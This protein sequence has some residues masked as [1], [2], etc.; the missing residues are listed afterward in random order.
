MRHLPLLASSLLAAPLLA[1]AHNETADAGNTIATAQI[2]A[3]S[4]PLASITGT[5]N[6]DAD[7]FV[8]QIDNPGTFSATVTGGT[9]GDSMLFL[10]DENG[11]G[12]VANDDN[13]GG[14]AAILPG[15]V[16]VPGRYWLGVGSFGLNA[17]T[18]GGALWNFASTT[19]QLQPNGPGGKEQLRS[20]TGPLVFTGSYTIALT[21]AS[22]LQK[23]V[24]LPSTAN[25]SANEGIPGFSLSGYFDSSGRRFQVI[26]SGS[27]FTDSGVQGPLFVN[28]ISFRGSD[29]KSHPATATWNGAVVRLARTAMTPAQMGNNFA[30]NL[31]AA[32]AVTGPVTTSLV[33]YPSIGSLPNN[34]NVQLDVGSLGASL[35]YDPAGATPNLLV[36]ILL[37]ALSS[38]DPPSTT[39]L[40][41]LQGHY[42][43]T[44]TPTT[45]TLLST[46]N[47]NAPS[48]TIG[49]SPVMAVDFTGGTGGREVVVPARNETVGFACGGAAS[50]F[51]QVFRFG[52][53]FDLT[54]L[55][56]TPDNVAAPTR[57]TV[58]KGTAA[59]DP[60]MVGA[61]PVST[62]DEAVVSVPLGFSFRF[63]GG[64]TTTLR[65]CT[66]GYVNLLTAT[67]ETTPS[68]A[69]LLGTTFTGNRERL[70]VYWQDLHCGANVATHPNSGL[71]AIVT[72]PAG[73]RVCYITWK[74]VAEFSAMPGTQALSMQCVL[75]EATGVIEYRYGSMPRF[76]TASPQD[77]A[78]AMVGF[79][80]GNIGGV[81]SVDP[82]TRDLSVELPFTTAV[83]GSLGNIRMRSLTTPVAGTF[84]H[85][86]RLFP[87]QQVH[88]EVTNLPGNALI[89]VQ[90]IDFA[91][92]QPG[93]QIPGITAP[94]CALATTV[95]ANIWE[96]HVVPSGPGGANVL[97]IPNGVE[98]AQIVAQYV[99]LNGLFAGGDLATHTS[100]A[101]RH[102]IGRR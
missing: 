28:R 24:V 41:L 65:A 35:A 1:Q 45:L 33:M 34:W 27:Q 2:V 22:K 53:A 90:L 7:L 87:G 36:D 52:D 31:A 23:R 84:W 11:H 102:T 18:A 13:G 56:L 64:N 10:F 39:S 38:I 66:N 78:A 75:H 48:G 89:G 72:G 61:T 14:A 47:G 51:Y 97:T 67:L 71:H 9:L 54:S 91:T 73:N 8:I 17:D 74:D 44:A 94:G 98:G 58:T 25:L 95:N 16:K 55:V 69:G 60:T 99:L 57:Y 5:V 43:G 29:G 77:A 88:W 59:Y 70:A 83:E 101:I 50:S 19:L 96:V 6:G 62:L 32:A 3:G 63:P 15:Q 81:G 4:G 93:L 80:R 26:Y 46:G 68:V 40:P 20:I 79:S 49:Y 76:A 37:P 100:N 21:G 42:D 82:Q 92:T 30:A 12:V 85:G 86:G